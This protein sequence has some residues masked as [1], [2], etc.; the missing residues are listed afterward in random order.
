MTTTGVS[1]SKIK[2]VGELYQVKGFSLPPLKLPSIR[3][4][5]VF[6]DKYN[7]LQADVFVIS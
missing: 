6:F 1:T 7:M 3:R 4:C 5:F 2:A